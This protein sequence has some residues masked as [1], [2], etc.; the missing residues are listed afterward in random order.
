MVRVT[1][2]IWDQWS[3]VWK[4]NLLIMSASVP[5]VGPTPSF[6]PLLFSLLTPN[7]SFHPQLLPYVQ[8]PTPSP[9][10]PLLTLTLLPLPTIPIALS[11]I[12]VH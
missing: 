10:L 7:L 3:E 2:M 8:T 1:D 9:C 5:H 6:L 12:L 4:V 11:Q